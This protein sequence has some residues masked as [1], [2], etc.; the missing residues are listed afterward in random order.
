MMNSKK[1]TEKH[2]IFKKL[3]D[4]LAGIFLDRTTNYVIFL[5]ALPK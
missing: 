5:D 1:L 2:I 4:K 3:R